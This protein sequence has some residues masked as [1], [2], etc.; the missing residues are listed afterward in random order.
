M[1]GLRQHV[2]GLIPPVN[3]AHA[4]DV[5]SQISHMHRDRHEHG[6][7]LAKGR[8]SRT[9]QIHPSMRVLSESC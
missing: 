1:I 8:E 7:P 3:V 6:H 9:Q 2:H 5:R 4:K